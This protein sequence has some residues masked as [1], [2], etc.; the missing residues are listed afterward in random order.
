ML[1]AI[2]VVLAR[3]FRT[4]HGASYL[5]GH[6]SMAFTSSGNSVGLAEFVSAHGV[7]PLVQLAIRHFSGLAIFRPNLRPIAKTLHMPIVVVAAYRERAVVLI[8]RLNHHPLFTV[9]RNRANHVA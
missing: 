3:Q 5:Q 1:R 8:L 7:L 6:S 2:V 9:E 4:L